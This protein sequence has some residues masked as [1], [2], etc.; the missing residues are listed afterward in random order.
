MGVGSGHLILKSG[1]ESTF[2]LTSS[3]NMQQVTMAKQ[4][5]VLK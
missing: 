5:K 1:L 4:V 3:R 2:K